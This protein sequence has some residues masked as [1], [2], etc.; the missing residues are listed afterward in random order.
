MKELPVK[1]SQRTR[2]FM[3]GLEVY[4]F[5]LEEGDSSDKIDEYINTKYHKKRV[6]GITKEEF[7]SILDKAS[8]PIDR[9]A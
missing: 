3:K 5:Q 8:Q 2:G 9:E 6:E 1:I 7:L 4:A